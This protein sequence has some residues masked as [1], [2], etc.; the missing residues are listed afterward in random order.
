[1]NYYSENPRVP[2]VP[3]QGM[4]GDFAPGVRV[5]C[6][7]LFLLPAVCQFPFIS[8]QWLL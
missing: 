1:M 3:L 5:H 2:A 8:S 7:C 6:F 4:L